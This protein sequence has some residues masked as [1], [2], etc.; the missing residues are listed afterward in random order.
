[1][2]VCYSPPL[3]QCHFFKPINIFVVACAKLIKNKK[4]SLSPSSLPSDGGFVVASLTSLP[5]RQKQV[6]V[7]VK[8]LLASKCFD[9]VYVFTP[10]V[11]DNVFPPGV[12]NVIIEHD[13]GPATKVLP[14]LF[15]ETRPNTIIVYCDDDHEYT[16]NYMEKLVQAARNDASKVFCGLLHSYAGR[17]LAAGH[18]AVAFTRGRVNADALLDYVQTHNDTCRVSDDLLLTSFFTDKCGLVVSS[19][20]NYKF[21]YTQILK[22]GHMKGLHTDYKL[23]DEYAKCMQSVYK[24]K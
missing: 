23:S 15:F 5:E 24:H 12:T 11:P 2:T 17:K 8:S 3:T 4:M 6:L 14:V 20:P 10:F 19:V 21:E 16:T 18:A 22:E 1:V 7:T 9:R 13:Y